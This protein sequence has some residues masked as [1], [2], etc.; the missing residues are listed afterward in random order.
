MSTALFDRFRE[1]LGQVI[2]LHAAIALLQWDQEVYMPPKGAGARGRQIATLSALAHRLFT[3]AEMAGLLQD[4]ASAPGGVDEDAARL[5]AEARYDFERAVRL[6]EAFVQ[7]FAEEQSRAYHAWVKAREDS[8]FAAFLPHLETLI[9]LLR[10]KADYLGY[11]GSPYNALLEEF[12]R[13]MRTDTLRGIFAELAPRQSALVKRIMN[14]PRQP[15]CAWVDRE[16]NE[17]AQ[18][19]LSVQVLEAMGYDFAAGRQDKSV[20]PFTTNFDLHDVRITTR[21]NPRDPFSGLMGS[22]HEGGHALYEQG[23]QEKDQRTLLAQAPSLG[24]HESQSRFWENIIGR[25]LAFWRHW[26]PLFR[27]RF[28]Q[29]LEGVDA[30]EVWRAVNRVRPSLIRVEADECT[31]NLH[32]ILRFEIEVALIEGQ[33]SAREIPEAWNAKMKEYLGVDVPD[34]AQ[35]CL[36]DIHWAHGA[37]GYF[38]TYALGN[39]YAAQLLESM[40]RAVPGLWE[41]VGQG[42]FQPILGWLREHV[43]RI[44]RRRTAS[45]IVLEAT[46]QVPSPDAFLRYLEAKYSA[47]YGLPAG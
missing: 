19:A 17:Q 29:A 21:I 44:G 16:W 31:Y 15:D 46:G 36:Q 24:I 9:E 43:H 39:L 6:P 28:P 45:E 5:A 40:Q 34:D 13:G 35:G 22:I 3:D 7:R 8:N 12:E 23:F 20:H 18:W 42:A 11:E 37:M 30:E 33:M 47:I 26:L 32:I 25:S 41:G 10:Q 14:S 2:D 4:L 27:A 38:P 1:R